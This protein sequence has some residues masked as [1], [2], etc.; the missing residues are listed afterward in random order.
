MLR[1][2]SASILSTSGT[3]SPAGDAPAQLPPAADAVLGSEVLDCRRQQA[4]SGA[5][6]RDTA[7]LRVNTSA[8]GELPSGLAA[9]GQLSKGSAVRG[10]VQ[11]TVEWRRDSAGD[12]VVASASTTLALP[13]RSQLL[14]DR[15]LSG[16][17]CEGSMMVDRSRRYRGA[18]PMR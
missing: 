9:A 10:L 16:V 4:N 5:D 13:W 18:G 17:R 2:S 1:V 3:R 6:G 15:A 7:D 8:R 14:G 12:A 11:A